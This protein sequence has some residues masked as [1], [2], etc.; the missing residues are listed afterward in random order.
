MSRLLDKFN[1]YRALF[2]PAGFVWAVRSKLART[3]QPVL[4]QT[5]FADRPLWFRLKTS[6]VPIAVQIF[7]NRE[8]R[9][10]PRRPVRTVVDA[11]A[12]TG[13]SALSFSEQFPEAQ[14]VALEP[15]ASNFKLLL[16]NTKPC[17][18]IHCEQAALWNED[19]DLDVV[20]WFGKCGFRTKPAA[21]AM[22]RPVC[23]RTPG[24][25][26]P[27]L[28]SRFGMEQIDF[29]KMDVE[30]AEKE[31][32]AGNPDWLEKVGVLAVELHDWLDPE[33][34]AVFQ[35]TAGRFE[36]HWQQGENR[37]CAKQGWV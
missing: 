34:S 14:I 19:T 32:L 35:K 17:L 23:G 1:E 15:E 5:K 28:M 13:F 11:G 37:F 10:A 31:I 27:T 21:Q 25:T 36:H 9:F 26:M 12:N 2:G 18:R 20:D 30:G 7:V 24:I 4:I 33:C 29:L 3:P 16:E 6:D 8:Y 22:S